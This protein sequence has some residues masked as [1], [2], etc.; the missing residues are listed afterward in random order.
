M[1]KDVAF[2][3]IKESADLGVNS[4]KFNWRGESS[5]NPDFF[6]ILAYAKSLARGSTF[7]ERLS[8]SNFKFNNNRSDVFEGFSCQTK[9]KISFDSFDKEVFE[10]QRAG[11]KHELAL[12][13][14]DTFYNHP[15]R[16]KSGTEIVIQ[17][18]R[19][20]RNKDE[21]IYGN[22]KRRWPSASVSIRDVVS[23]RLE[24]DISDI[25]VKA[26]DNSNRQSC[27]Q[28]HVRLIFNHE[29]VA[30]PCCPSIKEQLHV[31]D[32]RTHSLRE[33]FNSQAANQIRRDLKSGKA[34]ELD[35]CKTC[36]SFESYKGFK[37]SWGS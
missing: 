9:V 1:Q 25:E 4:L 24:G 26:R 36:S 19:T 21:D 31:G 22:V 13:N 34:F 37:P 29:G 23:G 18:V 33:I 32:I 8:N 12:K 11:G 17:A 16:I 3:I 27:L 5:L 30:S 28:A 15:S 35:P 6:E 2:K 10:V 20:Q 7:I 14:I